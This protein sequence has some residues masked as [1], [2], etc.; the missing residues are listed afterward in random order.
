MKNLPVLFL[1]AAALVAGCNRSSSQ[2]VIPTISLD[3]TNDSSQPSRAVSVS[4]SAVV[5]PVA[6]V[7]LGFPAGG[8]VKAV[9]VAAGDEVKAGQALV[10]LDTAVL[11]ARVVEAEAAVITAQ[12]QLAFLKRNGESQERLDAAQATIDAAQ[13][14]VGIA[15]AQLEQ[16]TLRAPFDGTIA[17]VDISPAEFANPG[18]ILVTMGDLTQFQVKTTDLSEND[19]ILVNTGQNARVYI[20]ALNQE[21]SGKV[22]DVARVASTIGG[23]VVYTI[24]IELD[25]QPTGLRWGMSA[26]VQIET[27]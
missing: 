10:T 8:I 20:E 27:E 3:S 14:V 1:I 16:A 21:V 12:T 4:A 6:K 26:E 23:D 5:M 25:E 7:E 22:I 9:D 2:E 11:E 17:S 15:K 13:A 24:T 18:Q 19:V